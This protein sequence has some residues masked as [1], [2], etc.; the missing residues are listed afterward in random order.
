[1]SSVTPYVMVDSARAFSEFIKTALGAEITATIPL[2]TDPERN[3][4]WRGKDR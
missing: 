4:A 3:H 2:P 1:M